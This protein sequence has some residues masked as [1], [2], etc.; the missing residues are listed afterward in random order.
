MRKKRYK[1]REV[2]IN[3]EQL[4]TNE[5]RTRSFRFRGNVVLHTFTVVVGGIGLAVVIDATLSRLRITER[6]ANNKTSA[7]KQ[8][9]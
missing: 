1:K 9:Y 5:T 7:L 3:T 2:N 6:D 8:V 4:N